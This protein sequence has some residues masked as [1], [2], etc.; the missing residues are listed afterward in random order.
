MPLDDMYDDDSIHEAP[1]RQSLL[2]E[3][4]ADGDT[5]TIQSLEIGRRALSEDPRMMF[6]T[7]LS[8]RFADL[9]EL[10]VDGEEFE[11]DGAFINRRADTDADQL[12]QDAIDEALDNTTTEIQALTGQ[13]VRRTSDVDLGIFG[14]MDEPDEPTFRFNIPQH[15]RLPPVR[16]ETQEET[17]AVEGDRDDI[18]P[19]IVQ[20]GYENE[21]DAADATPAAAGS[22][23]LQWDSDHDDDDVQAYREEPSAIDRSLQTGSP[24]HRTAAPLRPGRQRKERHISRHGIEYPEFPTAVLKR[25][26]A[27]FAKSQGSKPK[28]NKDTLAAIRQATEWYFEQV[29]EDLAAYAQHGGRKIIEEKDVVTLMKRY[30]AIRLL[31]I[32]C[33]NTVHIYTFRARVTSANHWL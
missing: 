6:T 12:L 7:R 9:N 2:P 19:E 3:L 17:P 25:L 18:T 8:E 15:I 13:R 23:H 31:Y 30:V 14:E 20:E 33:T 26:V 22:E 27:G 32:Y 28:I 11:M 16:E 21:D 4:P 5:A 1:P 24:E 29:G 10:G